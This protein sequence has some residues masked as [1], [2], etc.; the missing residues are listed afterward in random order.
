MAIYSLATKKGSTGC[1]PQQIVSKATIEKQIWQ[2]NLLKLAAKPTQ[3]HK[4]QYVPSNRKWPPPRHNV[5]RKG[6]SA[7]HV[8]VGHD[9]ES[10]SS[11]VSLSAHQLQQLLQLL[12]T[13]PQLTSHEFSEESL[14]SSFSGMIT[15]YNVQA[16]STDWIMDTGATNHMT[17]DLELLVNKKAAA[18]NM[19]VNLPTGAKAVVI[20][21]ELTM[22]FTEGGVECKSQNFFKF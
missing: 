17:Y 1:T 9:I 22:R 10:S 15:C 12:P 3:T 11:Q 2:Q 19:I 14:D 18:A 20:P 16:T 13:Q 21:S 4:N 7:D 6:P 5:S 8:S